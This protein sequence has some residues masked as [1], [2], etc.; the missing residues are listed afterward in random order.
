MVN[1]VGRFQE[2]TGILEFA[3]SAFHDLNLTALDG[4]AL[5][6]TP[7]KGQVVLVVNVASKC[8]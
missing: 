7:L 6:L 5:P 1:A 2:N 3:M 8:G 4:K